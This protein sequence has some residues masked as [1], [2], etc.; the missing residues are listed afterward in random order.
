MRVYA[1]TDFGFAP[2]DQAYQ[3]ILND[4][5]SQPA[6]HQ[7]SL[8]YGLGE[9]YESSAQMQTDA[10]YFASHGG[11]GVTVF[12]SAGDGGSSPGPNGWED[13]TGPVQVECPANDPKCYVGRRHQSSP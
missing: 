3:T 10:Q 6:L 4:L 9:T 13:N 12:V 1:T 2:L 8:S 5:P 7:V 11:H